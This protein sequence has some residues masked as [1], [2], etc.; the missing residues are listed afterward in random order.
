MKPRQEKILKTIISQYTKTSQPVGSEYLAK[1]ITPKIS[2]ATIRNEMADLTARD[3]LGQPYTSA[4]RVPTDKGF[5]YYVKNLLV[6]RNLLILEK[7]AL[8]SIKQA[9][10]DSPEILMKQ[11]AKQLAAL[12]GQLSVL[13]FDDSDFYYTG[14]SYLFSQPEFCEQ[15]V[16][17]SVSRVVDHLDWIMADIFSLISDK[18]EIL[19]GE[20]NPFSKLCG[21]VITRCQLPRQRSYSLMGLLG[22]VRMDYNRNIALIDYV[23]ELLS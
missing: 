9:R 6:K 16:V 3:Y 18:T 2:S 14:L 4:G 1:K 13:A 22:P 5:Q 17:Y 12:A 15:D 10:I 11:I 20:K 8:K 21:T 7:R 23:K 19:I